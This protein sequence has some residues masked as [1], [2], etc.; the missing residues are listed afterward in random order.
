MNTP[1]LATIMDI[2]NQELVISLKNNQ[3]MKR[4]ILNELEKEKLR[5]IY[6]T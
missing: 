4:K 3:K 6:N 1:L 2:V 5:C